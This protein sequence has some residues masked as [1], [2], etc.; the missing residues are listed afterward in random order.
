[1]LI[2]TIVNFFFNCTLFWDNNSHLLLFR[3]RN[4]GPTR[5]FVRPQTQ[6]LPGL[7]RAASQVQIGITNTLS[8]F[9]SRAH[10]TTVLEAT[11]TSNGRATVSSTPHRSLRQMISASTFLPNRLIRGDSM[12]SNRA[13]SGVPID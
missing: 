8:R 1:M 12:R 13:V 2:Q 6:F 10:L 11:N 5:V 9:Q 3:V 4:T 7:R